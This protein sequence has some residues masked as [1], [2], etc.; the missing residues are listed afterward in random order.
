ML[1]NL[2][3]TMHE[4]HGGTVT[5]KSQNNKLSLKRASASL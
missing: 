4:A 2:F 1:V 3:K 5:M